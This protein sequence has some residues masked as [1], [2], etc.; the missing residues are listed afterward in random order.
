R[1]RRRQAARHDISWYRARLATP[2]V[3][4]TAPKP[5]RL[6]RK[7]EG[8]DKNKAEPTNV[9]ASEDAMAEL[10]SPT[11]SREL[12]R[13]LAILKRTLFHWRAAS[14]V[15]V[16]V[17]LGAA[18]LL[19]VRKPR[20]RSETVILYR[21]GIRAS[22]LGSDAGDSV[23]N[24]GNKLR[25]MLFARPRLEKIIEEFDLYHDARQKGGDV[26]AVD[27]FRNNIQFKV[28]ATDTF[29]ISFDGRTPDEVQAVTSRLA[30]ALVEENT[31]LR[32]E[33][34]RIQSE[35]LAAEK[36]RSEE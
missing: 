33:Q 16:V 19:A 17:L 21:E 30:E 29:A 6:L 31:R 14:M 23:R 7:V 2:G 9:N 26:A 3:P 5:R 32:I 13:A 15:V 28:R 22:Y 1:S 25:E 18:A 8:M 27:E 35:F 11:A 36:Q 4:L 34:A 10:Q 20:F 12:A 24:L